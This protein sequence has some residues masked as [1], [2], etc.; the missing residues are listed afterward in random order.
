MTPMQQLNQFWYKIAVSRVQTRFK[1]KG[2]RYFMR[3]DQTKKKSSITAYNSKSNSAR[4]FELS[5]GHFSSYLTIQI[6]DSIYAYKNK[7]GMELL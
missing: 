2:P 6:K 3:K 5:A 1:V 4:N 7:E